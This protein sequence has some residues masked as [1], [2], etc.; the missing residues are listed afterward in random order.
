MYVGHVLVGKIEI[1]KLKQYLVMFEEFID[2][3]N[4]A[5]LRS[6]KNYP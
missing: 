2:Q 4:A 5:A 3:L 1:F 6:V